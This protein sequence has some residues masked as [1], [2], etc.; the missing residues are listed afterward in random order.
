M[1]PRPQANSSFFVLHSSFTKANIEPF[2][3]AAKNRVSVTSKNLLTKSGIRVNK[4]NALIFNAKTDVFVRRKRYFPFC[5][6]A[7]AFLRLYELRSGRAVVCTGLR[8]CVFRMG[9]YPVRKVSVGS[10]EMGL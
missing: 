3:C 4:N 9:V 2:T 6:A 5:G 7:R 1:V 8:V 10:G